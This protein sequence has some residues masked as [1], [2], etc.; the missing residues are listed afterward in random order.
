MK[1]GLKG[2]NKLFKSAP[3]V[4][5][6]WLTRGDIFN[7]YCTEIGKPLELVRFYWQNQLVDL[8]VLQYKS[9]VNGQ[10]LPECLGTIFRVFEIQNEDFEC[11]QYEN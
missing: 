9:E 4:N 5:G 3:K 11:V 1:K 10:Q 6:K 8:D 7:L 2:E